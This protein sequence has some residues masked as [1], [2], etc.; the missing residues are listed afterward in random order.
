ML[1]NYK[2]ICEDAGAG[3]YEA[4]PDICRCGNGDL[5]CV[6]YAGYAHVSFPCEDLPRGARVCSVRSTDEGLTWGPPQVVVDTPWDDR[7]PSSTC[8]SN[9]TLW[10]KWFTYYG[11]RAD[12]RPGCASK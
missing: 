11:G 7:D 1:P 9:G 8:L 5:L 3:G 4:F 12:G 2:V 10:C 6:F